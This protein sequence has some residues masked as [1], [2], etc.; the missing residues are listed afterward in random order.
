V[1]YIGS[2]STAGHAG[3]EQEFGCVLHRINLYRGPCWALL[4][5]HLPND[6]PKHKILGP[7]EIILPIVALSLGLAL[8]HHRFWLWLVIV[9]STNVGNNTSHGSDN[10]TTPAYVPARWYRSTSM[11][12]GGLSI[13]MAVWLVPKEATLS[14]MIS[15]STSY[16]SPSPS[17]TYGVS[18]QQ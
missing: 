15:T 1:C 10:T 5:R 9:A 12:C 3:V 18:E 11:G 16:T 4:P 17:S 6:D 7:V 8:H 2:I 14:S 13:H